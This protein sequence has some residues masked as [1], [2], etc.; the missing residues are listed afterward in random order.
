MAAS[1]AAAEELAASVAAKLPPETQPNLQGLASTIFFPAD[2]LGY[3]SGPAGPELGDG[4]ELLNVATLEHLLGEARAMQAK[5]YA[6]RCC[7]RALPSQLLDIGPEETA[8]SAWDVFQVLDTQMDHLQT[9]HQWQATVT[10]KFTACMVEDFHA[11]PVHCRSTHPAILWSSVRLVDAL[12]VLDN[13]KNAK[14]SLAQDLQWY[15]CMDNLVEEMLLLALKVAEEP[16]NGEGRERL[17]ALRAIP[18]LYFLAQGSASTDATFA[19][20]RCIQRV[21]IEPVVAGYCD[22]HLQ[23]AKMLAELCPFLRQQIPSPTPA[24]LAGPANGQVWCNQIDAHEPTQS[25]GGQGGPEDATKAVE[26]AGAALST[27]Q[28]AR[29]RLLQFHAWKN[30]CLASDPGVHPELCSTFNSEEKGVV[31][32]VIRQLKGMAALLSSQALTIRKLLHLAMPNLIRHFLQ[33]GP[34]Q[35][36][37]LTFSS[38]E[39]KVAG[40][41]S[42]QSTRQRPEVVRLLQDL[43]A[44]AALLLKAAE[45]GDGEIKQERQMRGISHAV[46]HLLMACGSTFSTAE[47]DQLAGVLDLE[48]FAGQLAVFDRLLHAHAIVCNISDVSFLWFRETHMDCQPRHCSPPSCS[49]PW[50]LVLPLCLASKD[51]DAELAMVPLSIYND[52]ASYALLVLQQRFLYDEVETEL[53]VCFDQ[54][55]LGVSEAMFVH[56]KEQVAV[57]LLD[58]DFV[59]AAMCRERLGVLDKCWGLVSQQRALQLVGRTVD[60]RALLGQRAS[61]LVADNLAFLV[62][63]A[64]AQSLCALVEVAQQLRVLQDVHAVV[65]RLL[66]VVPFAAL[67]ADINGAP[68]SARLAAHFVSEVAADLLPN[69]VYCHTTRRFVRTPKHCQ[70]PVRRAPAPAANRAF[71]AY[72]NPDLTSSFAFIA[73]LHGSFIGAQHVK[74]M[75]ELLGGGQALAGVVQALLGV[76]DQKILLELAPH[77]AKLLPLLPEAA[78]LPP[79]E[80]G[81]AAV[82]EVLEAVGGVA[83]YEAMGDV[84]QALKEVGTVVALLTLLDGGALRPA[85][86]QRRLQAA[87]LAAGLPSELQGSGAPAEIVEAADRTAALYIAETGS[88]GGGRGQA[89]LLRQGLRHLD[90]VLGKVRESWGSPTPAAALGGGPPATP[91]PAREAHRVLAAAQLAF[92]GPGLEGMESNQE[93]YGDASGGVATWAQEFVRAGV[94]AY[95]V[96]CTEEGLRKELEVLDLPERPRL[97]RADEG[98]AVQLGCRLAPEEV[99]ECIL[100]LALVFITIMGIPR[101]MVLRWSSTSAVSADALLQWRGFTQLIINAYYNQGMAWFSIPRLQMEQLAVVGEAEEASIVADRMRLIFATLEV[102]EPRWG[103]LEP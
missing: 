86:R 47:A 71:S 101:T 84:L 83:S 77:V 46:A 40:M 82:L 88:G 14:S 49:I 17:T 54:V 10:S 3:G 78:R 51:G 60:L 57:N 72:G 58:E 76:L 18:A 93:R 1:C 90:A 4:D 65:S 45:D 12:V 19:M 38:K 87:P 92:C 79:P 100:W 13:L 36:L 16:E 21:Q 15:R 37:T 33:A 67:L 2:G 20:E 55:V 99:R 24:Q 96:G 69:F 89:P 73:E 63:S 6:H 29:E 41:L 59:A 43:C 74:A 5:L 66:P 30:S 50:A 23:V 22:S 97:D 85:S 75:A 7:S 9:I 81:P 102:I 27:M 35:H 32:E 31:I 39:D 11:E 56:A 25:N 61:C 26:A 28:C 94:T 70:R 95:S 42:Q 68:L 62:Q 98:P 52:A 80:L 8:Q 64:A 34:Q 48:H 103:G 53:D 44:S 91:R